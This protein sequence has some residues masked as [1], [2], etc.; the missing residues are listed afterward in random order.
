MSAVR[1]DAGE[2]SGTREIPARAH[3]QDL[4]TVQVDAEA[5]GIDHDLAA[6]DGVAEVEHDLAYGLFDAH[7][8]DTR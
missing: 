6:Q 5:A 2:I 7:A 1:F 8:L 4:E 3:R